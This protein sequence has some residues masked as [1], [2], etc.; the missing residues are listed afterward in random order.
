ML[1]AA[2]GWA[3]YSVYLMYWKFKFNFFIRFTI[4][5]FFGSLSLLP[6]Y[7][8]EE[9]FINETSFDLNFIFWVMFGAISPGIIA[10]SLY[11]KVQKYLGASLTGFTLYLYTIY[12]AIYGIIFFGEELQS[13]HY[14]GATFVLIGVY[15]AK[16]N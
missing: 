4:I 9:I 16:K 15:F 12:A 1:G 10:F 7:L 13:F 3:L 14:L 8:M 5:S 6:F 2:L 11:A